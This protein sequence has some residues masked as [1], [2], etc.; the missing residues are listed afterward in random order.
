MKNLK[1]YFQRA[2]EEKWAMP[3]FNFSDFSQV[4][5]IV[6][7]CAE[8]K[9]PVILGTSEGES[10]FF[11][12][13][14]AVALRNVLR[15]KTGLPIFLNLDHGKSLDYVKK[16]ID[17]G[18]DMVHFDGS[19]LP[20]E[21]NIKITKEVVKYAKWKN[22]L[23]EGEVGKIGTDSSRLYSEKFEI[24]EED[25]TKPEEAFKFLKET[26]ANLLAVSIGSFHGIEISGIDPN[27]RLDVL[28]AVKEKVGDAFLVLHGGSGTPEDDIKEAIKSGIV[29]ININTELRMAFAGNLRRALSSTEEIVP[30]K[31]LQEA[32]KSV[33]KVVASKVKLFDSANKIY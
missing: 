33:E 30:Y 20:L 19:K 2:Q 4:R 3:Q 8:M 5:G 32:I 21:E 26:K 11:G 13:E 12:L 28:K 9:S 16:A 15:N 18:Y 25:L 10:K 27:L 29:K 23:V 31:F 24:K 22:V 14:E 17:A 1:Y 7:K 6:N